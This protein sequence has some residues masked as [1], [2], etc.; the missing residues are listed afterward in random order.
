L[1]GPTG[2]ASAAFASVAA[3]LNFGSNQTYTTTEVVYPS[4]TA[5]HI[6]WV[7]YTSRL[8][9]VAVCEQT[10]GIISRTP[11]VGFTIFGRAPSGAIGTFDVQ[12]ILAE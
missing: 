1:Q 9:D 7:Q 10:C 11:G 3:V 4:L 8:E 12:C 6:I 5:T 2:S